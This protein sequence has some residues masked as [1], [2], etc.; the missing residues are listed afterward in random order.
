ML[1][2]YGDAEAMR[3]IGDGQPITEEQCTKWH[4]VTGD[5][6]RVRGYGMFALVERNTQEVIGFCGRVHP[7]G[8]SEAEL[9]YALAHRYWGLSLATE[10]ATAMLAFAS[11]VADLRRVMATTAP[12]N[13]ASHNVLLKAGM[14]REGLRLEEDGSYTQV[15]GWRH[16][17][18][19]IA[20]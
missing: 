4:G 2:I 5:N 6:Y 10:A 18:D 17:E 16:R 19:R 14:A 12:E 3:W 9:K 7:G 20:R 1:A 11:T 13:I 8:Q 15:F